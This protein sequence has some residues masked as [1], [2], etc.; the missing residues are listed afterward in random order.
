MLRTRI[1]TAIVL[2]LITAICFGVQQPWLE[3]LYI[4]VWLILAC[5]EWNRL[6]LVAHNTKNAQHKNTLW[7][8]TACTTACILGALWFAQPNVNEIPE[9]VTYVTSIAWLVYLASMLTLGVARIRT[10]AK[11]VFYVIGLFLLLATSWVLLTHFR[12]YAYTLLSAMALVWV[13][14]TGA[15]FAGRAFGKNKLAPTV[16]PGKTWEG[17]IGGAVAVCV[18][19]VAWAQYDLAQP[20]WMD[21]YGITHP[22]IY[23]MAWRHTPWLLLL[24]VP[25]LLACSVCGDLVESIAKRIADIKDSSQLLPG[26]GGVLDRIDG[27][28]PTLPVTLALAMWLN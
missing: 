28:L 14:D 4:A 20:Q 18:L 10:N 7:L 8:L 11:S 5:W 9:A 26:H 12:P 16:S 25:L 24:V 6:M 19:A 17:V 23:A 13:A 2:L 21:A 15:Y 1:L 27:L 22:S 3:R